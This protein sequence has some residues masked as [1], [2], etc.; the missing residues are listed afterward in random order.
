MSIIDALKEK[1]H[2]FIIPDASR[3]DLPQFFKDM[4]FGIGAEIGVY[5]GEFTEKFKDFGMYA[6]DPWIPYEGG[7]S[8]HRRADKQELLYEE[9][10]KRLSAP[11]FTIIRKTSMEAVKEFGDGLLDFV[12]IDGDHRYEYVLEDIRSWS[13]KVRK[14][15]VVAGHDYICTDP[16]VNALP[17]KYQ[18]HLQVG[19]A[20]DKYVEDM[21]AFYVLGGGGEDVNDNFLSW[22]FIK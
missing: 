6:I 4:G 3:S 12:Y 18:L 7:G 11:N 19:K 15:G 20:V 21:E 2:P 8:A 16:K 10:K 5:K 17:L 9:A 22:F 14:G 13:K 1:G